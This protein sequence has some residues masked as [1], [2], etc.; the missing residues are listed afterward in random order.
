MLTNYPP[1]THN[2]TFTGSGGAQ[3]P[4]DNQLI[5]PQSDLELLRK[6]RCCCTVSMRQSFE[7]MPDEATSRRFDFHV[8]GKDFSFAAASGGRSRNST[9]NLMTD[10][11]GGISP[12][13][14]VFRQSDSPHLRRTRSKHC[15]Q[16]GRQ[17]FG[18][19]SVTAGK[20]SLKGFGK[21]FTIRCVLKP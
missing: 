9:V 10:A 16:A 11:S 6:D 3:K 5:Q 14:P 15:R 21:Q 17:P 4:F 20:C 8:A 12:F 1:A 13:G 2:C 7:E 18:K 19:R